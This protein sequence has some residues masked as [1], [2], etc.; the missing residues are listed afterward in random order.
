V[1]QK[2]VFFVKE[3]SFTDFNL[4]IAELFTFLL[5]ALPIF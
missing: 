4:N 3:M 2:N 5:A 1:R